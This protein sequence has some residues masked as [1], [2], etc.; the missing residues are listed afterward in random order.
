MKWVRDGGRGLLGRGLGCLDARNVH[1]C[2]LGHHPE[3][4]C[5]E[6]GELTGTPG[7]APS[8]LADL[9]VVCPHGPGVSNTD[10][11]RGLSN[12]GVPGTGQ[13]AAIAGFA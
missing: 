9:S 12:D 2:P 1:E 4:G 7:P 3:S 5:E 13:K 11:S 10:S 6:N 8:K